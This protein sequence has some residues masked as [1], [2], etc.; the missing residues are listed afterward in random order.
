MRRSRRRADARSALARAL[1]GFE[2]LDAIP[3]VARSRV[4]L[5]AAPPVQAEPLTPQE[6]RIVELVADGGTN[7]EIAAALHLGEKTLERRLTALYRKAGVA[8]RTE[9]AWTAVAPRSG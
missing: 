1:A 2:R 9:L 4:G 7:R 3:F 6:R 8:S 5:E